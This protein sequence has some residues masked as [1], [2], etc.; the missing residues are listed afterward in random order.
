MQWQV[1][2]ISWSAS[3]AA[4]RCLQL[5]MLLSHQGSSTD[6]DVTDSSIVMQR[7]DT[8]IGKK[9]TIE[10]VH[11][12]FGCFLPSPSMLHSKNKKYF[13]APLM[14]LQLVTNRGLERFNQYLE[15]PQQVGPNIPI[16]VLPCMDWYF[17]VLA[18]VPYLWQAKHEFHANL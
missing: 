1:L 13:Q 11:T 16:V 2:W 7:T 4:S 6:N 9:K 10:C 18:R 15:G 14:V 8:T 5:E 17:Q 12:L 3:L